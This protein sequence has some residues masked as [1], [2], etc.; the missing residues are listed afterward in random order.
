M[1]RL[2]CALLALWLGLSVTAIA[3][4]GA[5]LPGEAFPVYRAAPVRRILVENDDARWFVLAGTEPARMVC[6]VG[7][8]TA[9]LR[10][11]PGL[12]D[13]PAALT[14]GAGEPETRLPLGEA[15]HYDPAEGV[16][17]VE[18]AVDPRGTEVVLAGAGEDGAEEAVLWLFRDEAAAR[19]VL[20]AENPAAALEPADPPEEAPGAYAF[21]LRDQAGSA[22]AGVFLNIC[23]DTACTMMTSDGEGTVLFDGPVQNYHVQ[24]LAAPAGF[25]FEPGFGFYTGEA[26]GVWV[27]RIRKD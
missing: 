5:G 4:D 14:F 22:V 9:R 16:F 26:A 18:T 25:H 15:A 20:L 27:V 23:T 10:L 3:E 2:F 1:K 12:T 8:D 19:E 13:D 21:H 6:A 24:L 11:E 17:R 7:A